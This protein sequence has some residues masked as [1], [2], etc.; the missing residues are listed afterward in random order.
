MIDKKKDP[1]EDKLYLVNWINGIVKSKYIQISSLDQLSNG[2]V[3]C[4]LLNVLCPGKVPQ[5]KVFIKPKGDY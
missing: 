5:S 2:V 1:E 4:E 3:F